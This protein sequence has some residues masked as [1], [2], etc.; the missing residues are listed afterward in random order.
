MGKTG[1][2]ASL[3][4]VAVLAAGAAGCGHRSPT[5]AVAA[6]TLGDSSDEAL[7]LQFQLD[8]VNL[9][10]EPLRLREFRYRLSIDGKP[11]FRGRR[12]A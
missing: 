5:V 1:V 6:V 8:L 2:V 3:V 9:G 4:G 11:V 7:V 10:S 12:A